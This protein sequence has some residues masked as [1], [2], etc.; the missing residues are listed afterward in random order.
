M[1]SY[2]VRAVITFWEND[3]EKKI[4]VVRE[5][6]SGTYHEIDV[7]G[8]QDVVHAVARKLNVAKDKITVPEHVK[9]K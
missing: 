9:L 8:E 7:T 6:E 4:A 1:Q 5:K 3:R 2:E